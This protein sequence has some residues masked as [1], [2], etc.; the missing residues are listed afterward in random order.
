[1]N[2]K[3]LFSLKSLQIFH[4]LIQHIRIKVRGYSTL[5]KYYLW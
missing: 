1:M 5:K 3:K 2:Y 4:I